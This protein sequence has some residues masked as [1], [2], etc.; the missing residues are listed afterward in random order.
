MVFQ[1][2]SRHSRVFRR[3]LSIGFR[4]NVQV[5]G[6]IYTDGATTL[7]PT[8]SH[9]LPLPSRSVSPGERHCA[10]PGRRSGL[11]PR[12]RTLRN[13][14]AGRGASATTS[15]WNCP[16]ESVANTARNQAPT[17]SIANLVPFSYEH[18]H[19][20][21]VT[22]WPTSGT[23]PD[24][25]AKKRRESLAK[26]SWFHLL[27]REIPPLIRAATERATGRVASP[28]GQSLTEI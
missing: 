21:P 8:T 27:T 16:K 20:I 22:G 6:Y 4:G 7:L 26:R 10:P 9:I 3:R 25:T 17:R 13:P 24:E 12:R 28:S 5:R 19:R 14:P 18:D 23:F 1:Y 2:R 11:P 15:R